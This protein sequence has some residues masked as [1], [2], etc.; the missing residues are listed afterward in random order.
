MFN[1]HVESEVFQENCFNK[2]K[3]NLILLNKCFISHFD[4]AY[5]RLAEYY[6][7]IFIGQNSGE[8]QCFS[9]YSTT[10][11]VVGLFHT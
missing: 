1:F 4:H 5:K 11:S 7:L 9:V 8:F 2:N 3:S 6:P 10:T